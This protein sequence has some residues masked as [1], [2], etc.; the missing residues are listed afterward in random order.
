MN[1]HITIGVQDFD[2]T[3]GTPVTDRTVTV[4]TIQDE[5]TY[6]VRIG[7][8]DTW[9]PCRCPLHLDTATGQGTHLS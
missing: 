1:H 5:T 3:T 7:R 8:D 2:S 6:H 4:D 9:P